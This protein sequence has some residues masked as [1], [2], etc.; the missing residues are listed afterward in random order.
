MNHARTCTYACATVTLDCRACATDIQ[1]PAC[2][3]TL[4]DDLVPR[5]V[6]VCPS[7]GATYDHRHTPD[8]VPLVRPYVHVVTPARA[9]GELTPDAV[10]ALVD[11]IRSLPEVTRP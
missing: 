7:C 5:I 10:L 9:T 3:V 8:V 4:V 6:A 2:T 11:Q 1:V